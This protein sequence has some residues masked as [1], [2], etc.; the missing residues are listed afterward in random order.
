MAED[1][2]HVASDELVAEIT[3]QREEIEEDRRDQED[4]ED[5]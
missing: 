3:K 5:E 1:E 4:E 2:K